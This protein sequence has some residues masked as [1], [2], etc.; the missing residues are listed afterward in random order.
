MGNSIRRL[1][2][3]LGLL[4][5][6]WSIVGITLVA[7]VLTEAGFRA[8]FAVRD[9]LTTAPAPDRRV[10]AEGY[11]GASWPVTHYREL[12]LLAERWQPYVYFRQ[13]PVQGQTINID[14]D[15]LR[16]TWQP[17][18]DREEPGGSR[19]IKLLFLGGSSLWGYGARDDH[20]IPSL[21]AKALHAKSVKVEVRNLA[22]IGYVSTQE[23]VALIKELQ[24]G[25]RPDVVVFY[26]GVNDTTSALLEGEA[27]LTTNEINRRRE[28]NLSQ[29]PSRLAAALAGRLLV[30]SGSYRFAQ[31]VRRR[32]ANGDSAQKS[33]LSD[34]SIPALAGAV[35]RTYE[36]NVTLVDSL[37]KTYGFRPM[38]FWQPIAFTK[39]V[40][41]AV[42][43]EEAARYSWTKPMFDEVYARIRSS[44][45]L[46]ADPSFHDLSR[47]FAGTEALVFIDYCHTTESANALIAAEITRAVADSAR[48]GG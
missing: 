44:G 47:M 16:A 1:K 11:A 41:V 9:R 26:D 37:G 22:E 35:V 15:G 20:T 14:D 42:E 17:S 40:R 10:L 36:A 13:K 25:Y 39:P 46:Q 2:R 18:A 30:D 38:F 43:E 32:F 4:Q 19:P 12:A 29:S 5:T 6:T 33:S 48:P 27:G 23:V 3:A 34:E 8:F 21:V 31:S 45:P 28:F 24:A 7:V